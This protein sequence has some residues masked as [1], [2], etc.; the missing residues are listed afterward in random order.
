MKEIN[1]R[2]TEL[3]YKVFARH[4]V[5]AKLGKLLINTAEIQSYENNSQAIRMKEYQKLID[6]HFNSEK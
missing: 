4:K 5:P 1:I 2:K 6:Y 3:L